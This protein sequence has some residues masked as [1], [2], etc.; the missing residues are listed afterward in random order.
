[1][2]SHVVAGV[3]LDTSSTNIEIDRMNRCMFRDHNLYIGVT[4]KR[5]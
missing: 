2:K 1:M 3:H 5:K 4:K